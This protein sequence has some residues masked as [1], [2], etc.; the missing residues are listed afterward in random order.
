MADKILCGGE[1]YE[2]IHL[3]AQNSERIDI[4]VGCDLT[5]I[6]GSIKAIRCEKFGR[7][8][9]Q[10]PSATKRRSG[11]TSLG[12]EELSKA[13]VSQSWLTSVIDQNISLD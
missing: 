5:G 6:V 2:V 12:V 3:P 7:L 10:C 4:T 8:P 1:K 11:T 9:P 13:K